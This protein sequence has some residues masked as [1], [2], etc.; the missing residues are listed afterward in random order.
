M[1]VPDP[2]NFGPGP[3]VC[4]AV[5]TILGGWLALRIMRYTILAPLDVEILNIP[6]DE[7]LPWL[8]EVPR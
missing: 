1:Y 5:R 8:H 6:Q 2:D 3:D 4:V 7:N